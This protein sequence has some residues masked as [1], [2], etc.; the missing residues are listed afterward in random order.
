MVILPSLA[1][2]R[3]HR[4]SRSTSPTSSTEFKN[5]VYTL[6]VRFHCHHACQLDTE[7]FLRRS[8]ASSTESSKALPRL[9]FHTARGLV[10]SSIR[11]DN[12]REFA[13]DAWLRQPGFNKRS[14][15][16][17]IQSAVVGRSLANPSLRLT[18]L[19]GSLLRTPGLGT[20]SFR[21]YN[22][23][24]SCDAFGHP[25]LEIDGLPH[26]RRRVFPATS[27]GRL[28]LCQGAT[29]LGLEL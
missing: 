28:V 7:A 24:V 8:P 9:P 23:L 20:P 17:T 1:R 2:Y 6:A 10:G 12:D 3:R 19:I 5:A 16:Y 13:C 29:L 25:R 4:E 21:I 27:L 11:Q 15:G 26:R 18:R 22:S 14:A